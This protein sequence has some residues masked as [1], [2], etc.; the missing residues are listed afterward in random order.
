MIFATSSSKPV[1]GLLPFRELGGQRGEVLGVALH[2]CR[3]VLY[4]RQFEP[5]LVQRFS[6]LVGNAT[7]LSG[8]LPAGLGAVLSPN[9][10]Y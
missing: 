3:A 6:I 2:I 10:V 4:R 8:R 7:H 9:I 1:F 5:S